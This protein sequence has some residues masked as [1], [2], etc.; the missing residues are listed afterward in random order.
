[1]ADDD[2]Q[3]ILDPLYNPRMAN[4]KNVFDNDD[5]EDDRIREREPKPLPQFRENL[6]KDLNADNI[7]EA[8]MNMEVGVLG[9]PST[10][11][12]RNTRSIY[13]DQNGDFRYKFHTYSHSTMYLVATKFGNGMEKWWNL[14]SNSVITMGSGLQVTVRRVEKLNSYKALL[15]CERNEIMIMIENKIQDI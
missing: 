15:H 13:F 5:L 12:P 11:V 8:N 10:F 6:T 7:Q 9:W 4:V 1:M 14:W 3:T 2:R